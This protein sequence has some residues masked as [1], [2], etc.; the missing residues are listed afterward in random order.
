MR[1]YLLTPLFLL[2]LV[3]T[4]GTSVACPSPQAGGSHGPQEANVVTLNPGG[5]T[6]DNRGW[7][8]GWILH[9][10]V[11]P[12][13]IS[14]HE[15]EFF[16]AMSSGSAQVKVA[17]HLDKNGQ[18]NDISSLSGTIQVTST[19]GFR[20][21]TSNKSMFVQK[22]QPFYVGYKVPGPQFR[23]SLTSGSFGAYHYQANGQWRGPV[24]TSRFSWR[25]SSRFRPFIYSNDRSCNTGASRG[26]GTGNYGHGVNAEGTRVGPFTWQAGT[27]ISHSLS[28][29]RDAWVQGFSLLCHRSSGSG[30]M[31]IRLQAAD[32][33]NGEPGS[34]LRTG[35][36]TVDTRTRWCSV[37][38]D[39]AHFF[40]A[41]RGFYLTYTVPTGF[42]G[43]LDEGD[44]VSSYYRGKGSNTWLGP[45]S[46]HAFGVRILSRHADGLNLAAIGNATYGPVP[47]SLSRLYEVEADSDTW[48]SGFGFRCR[49]TQA[50]SITFSLHLV[51]GW[52]GPQANAVR[53]ATR[54]VDTKGGFQDVSFAPIFVARGERYYIGYTAPPASQGQLYDL[55]TSLS[56]MDE[57]HPWQRDPRNPTWVQ[58]AIGRKVCYRVHRAHVQHNPLETSN[59]TATAPAGST[60]AFLCT[61]PH[62][63]WIE[64][65]EC[66]AANTRGGASVTGSLYLAQ[67]RVPTPST[68]VRSGKCFVGTGSTWARVRFAEPYFVYGGNSFF[69]ALKAPLA[70]LRP[71]AAA[72]R[73]VPYHVRSATQT[74]WNGPRSS[75]VALRVHARKGAARMSFY[76]QPEIGK[77]F[78]I[79]LNGASPSRW[80]GLVLG[81]SNTQ[82]GPIQLPL[83]L[84][85]WPRCR[86]YVSYDVLLAAGGTGTQGQASVPVSI[87]YAPALTGQKI[88]T[89]FWVIEEP[90]RQVRDELD[91]LRV[92]LDWRLSEEGGGGSRRGAEKDVDAARRQT[93]R[94]GP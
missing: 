56:N 28:M 25:V 32:G 27:E 1:Q 47:T 63:M 18:P 70:T 90:E 34:I 68:S 88:Y 33:P 67:G 17:M 80:W 45:D 66:L 53:S 30:T 54:N 23:H 13:Y 87:P 8:Q 38:F 84:G 6:L 10:V 73:A 57:P 86:L 82:W 9:R 59:S 93:Q 50:A 79:E 5:G 29:P 4:T 77:S 19:P 3:F 2:C 92:A 11:A 81:Y 55:A 65:F 74:T 36:L 83:E 26:L 91:E 78:R 72:G 94:A 71:F 41:R 85:P 51:Q 46:T 37:L 44:P 60:H 24:T 7:P 48:V 40:S 15:F 76:G 21:F 35:Q 75:P 61:A 31:P 16:C 58:N 14:V 89:Q 42:G 62:D 49:T 12:R 64:G 69:V 20:R 22:G 39:S 52:R 43:A